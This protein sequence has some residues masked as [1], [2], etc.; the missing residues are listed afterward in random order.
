MIVRACAVFVITSCLISFTLAA[1]PPGAAHQYFSKDPGW[2]S[3]NNRLL[4]EKL[5]VTRQHF[6]GGDTKYAGGKAKGEI[7]GR[8]Q[9][10][11]TAAYYAMAIAPKTLNDKLHASGRLSVTADDGS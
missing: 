6:G 5:P 7:G 11:R 1:D 2:D 3:L 10:S 9:R 8:V 4:P